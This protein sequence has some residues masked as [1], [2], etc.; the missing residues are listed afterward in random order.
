MKEGGRSDR[1]TAT[2]LPS[3]DQSLTAPPQTP[4]D[5][6]DQETND[7]VNR[8]FASCEAQSD[9]RYMPW[10]DV[11]Q[12]SGQVAPALPPP[13][14]LAAAGAPSAPASASASQLPVL[15]SRANKENQDALPA[16]P[17]T[18]RLGSVYGPG[19]DSNEVLEGLH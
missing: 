12:C 14:S 5:L 6:N 10:L 4:D 11:W 19:F 18:K 17:A 15:T 3:P 8:M 1:L 7:L 16:P 2:D 13:P 9:S